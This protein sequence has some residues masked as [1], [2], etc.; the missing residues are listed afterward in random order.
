MGRPAEL[1]PRRGLRASLL[2]V[3][4][5]VASGGFGWRF[6]RLACLGALL[7]VPAGALA[8]K[9][10]SAVPEL[11]ASHRHPSGAF[12]FRTP[13]DWTV[14]STGA[15]AGE[16]RASGGGIIVRFRYR[17]G[18]AGFDSL[19]ATCVLERLADPMAAEPQVKYEY[20]YVDGQIGGRRSVDSAFA[21]RYDQPVLGH[22]EWRQRNLTIVDKGESL[23]VIA[24]VPQPSWRKSREVRD[25]LASVL[26]SLTFR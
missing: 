6:R 20:D 18:E 17:D 5:G 16:L 8:G 22:R 23:C 21:V 14:E 15:G 26:A 12:T 4:G 25:L 10:N 24:N 13:S 11:T 7:F 19:H 1:A 2:D 9:K 3:Q